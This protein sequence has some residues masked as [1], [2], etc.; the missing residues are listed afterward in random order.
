MKKIVVAAEIGTEGL[1]CW[2]CNFGRVGEGP[3]CVLFNRNRV[4]DAAVYKRLPECLSSETDQSDLSV[5]MWNK[6]HGRNK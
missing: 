2:G 6:I 4:R 3:R 1:N 5:A